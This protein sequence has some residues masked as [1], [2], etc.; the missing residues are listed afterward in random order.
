MRYEYFAISQAL[1]VV[2]PNDIAIDGKIYRKGHIVGQDDKLL[3]KSK[4]INSIYGALAESGDIDFKTAQNQISAQIS[5]KG[6]G[7]VTQTD[8]IC[9]IAATC[10]GL[11]MG[12]EYRIDKFNRINEN[13][14]LNTIKPYTKVKKG[15]VVAMLEVTP[16]FIIETEVDDIIFR[17]SGNFGLLSVNEIKDKKSAFIYPHLLNDNN[18]NIYF[19]SVAMKLIDNFNSIGL[20]IGKEINSK[21]DIDS[22]SDSL[23]SCKDTD[24]IFVLSPLK[25]SSCFDV[26]TQAIKKYADKIINCKY[27]DVNTSDFVVAQKGK[28]KIFVIPHFYD[29]GDTTKIDKLIKYVI[30]SDYIDEN[31]FNN[32][33]SANISQI[34]K[35]ILDDDNK[36]ISSDKKQHSK[37]KASV[38][39]VILAAGQAKRCGT[40]KLLVEGKDGEPLFMKAV[41]AA[42]SS[43]AKPIFVVTGY[44]HDEI[45]EYIKDYDINVV[46]NRAYETGVNSSISLGIKSIPASCDGAIL[47]PADMPNITYQELNK[48]IAKFDKNKEKAICVLSN[49]G[50][51]SNPILWSKSLYQKAQIIPENAH[52]R[53]VLIEHNDYVKEIEIKDKNKLLDIDFL[54]QLKD[55]CEK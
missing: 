19:T 6:L 24:I 37:E 4:G 5:A 13:V 31:I 11:F 16:P 29:L 20:N 35:L 18:E 49:K 47:L 36:F 50:V 38:G 3:F 26:M 23:Y 51:K 25:S 40:N 43:D 45:E 12:D 54:S 41:K 32:K 27:P 34:D 28:T 2:L 17:L 48:L 15:D 52:M 30:F 39:I 1:G 22:I 21:Y 53:A 10:D 55:Y 7:F 33:T 42:I 9:R 46:Y 14:I 8:G 44:N